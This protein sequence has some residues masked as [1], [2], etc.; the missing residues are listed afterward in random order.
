MRQEALR[1]LGEGL[2]ASQVL[3][4][5]DK[6]SLFTLMAKKILFLINEQPEQELTFFY[7]AAALSHIYRFIVT[8]RIE[9]GPFQFHVPEKAAF[10]PAPLTPS[11]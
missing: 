10:F 5:E 3:S 4:Y 11:P 2:F 9:S 8:H 7:T 1:I 6:T